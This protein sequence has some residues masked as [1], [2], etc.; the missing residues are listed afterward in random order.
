MSAVSGPFGSLLATPQLV[1]NREVLRPTYVP[2]HL[3]CR[4]REVDRLAALLVPL[5]RGQ[6]G[7]NVLVMGKPGS[8]KTALVRHVTHE[9]Q[10]TAQELGEAVHVVHVDCDVVDTTYRLLAQIAN[11]FIADWRARVPGT[12]WPTE[13]VVSSL[14]QRLQAESGACLVVLDRLDGLVRKVGPDVLTLL[15][16]LQLPRLSLVGVVRDA[17]P[18]ERAEPA[19]RGLFQEEV[20]LSA[21]EDR[22]VASILR[23]RAHL[24]FVTAGNVEEILPHIASQS[25]GNAGRAL[26][27]LR[28]VAE[29]SE[30]D[31]SPFSV[32]LV[33]RV[34][35]EQAEARIQETVAELPLASRLLLL[36]ALREAS[37]G[38]STTGS[39]YE[40]YRQVCEHARESCLTQRRVTDLLSELDKAEVLS[41]RVVSRG[42]YG[43]SKEVLVRSPLVVAAAL[44][45]DEDVG[46]LCGWALERSVQA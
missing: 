25:Q 22:E 7:P 13:E 4:K 5:L 12:G 14:K 26:G 35:R 23:E 39:V 38:G 32:H 45:R 28:G 11:H 2:S 8:G 42:R 30:R 36:A 43:R 27:L 6:A 20:S 19:L 1:R 31:G 10:R 46:P 44:R 40:A 24:A 17:R 34:A 21:F 15:T 33:Q 9:L 18:L 41:V 3:P 16:G 29:L 37:R